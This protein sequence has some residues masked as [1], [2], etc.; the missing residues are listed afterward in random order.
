MDTGAL[1]EEIDQQK[2][3]RGKGCLPRTWVLPRRIG[4]P[5]ILVHGTVEEA[6][7]HGENQRGNRMTP[8]RITSPD[9]LAAAS[10]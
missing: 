10:S 1:D 6:L 9:P 5:A 8:K 3:A 7:Q 2:V 4:Q